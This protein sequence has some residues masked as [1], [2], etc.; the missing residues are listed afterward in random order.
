M[1]INGRR[2]HLLALLLILSGISAREARSTPASSGCLPPFGKR[3]P[4]FGCSVALHCAFLLAAMFGFSGASGN[5]APLVQ[6]YSVRFLQLGIPQPTVFYVSTQERSGEPVQ[7]G[8]AGEMELP[9]GG[10]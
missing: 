10:S 4:A 6:H 7:E 3:W 5:T 9:L 8:G 1:T 2:M